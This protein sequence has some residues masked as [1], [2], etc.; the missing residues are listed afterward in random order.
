VHLPIEQNHGF[1]VF[2]QEFSFFC[3]K[4]VVNISIH[5]DDSQ[6]SSQK[7]QHLPL[8]KGNSVQLMDQISLHPT[9]VAIIGPAGTSQYGIKDQQQ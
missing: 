4:G 5:D 6:V 7:W 8:I 9:G 3:F 1:R 2:V